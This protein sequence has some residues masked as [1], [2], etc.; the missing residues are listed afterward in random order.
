MS[1]DHEHIFHR[2]LD[3][4]NV[5]ITDCQWVDFTPVSSLVSTLENFLNT[6]VTTREPLLSKCP[7]N[8]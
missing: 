5:W 3:L 7:V 2:S 6:E 4:L 1:G 8:S